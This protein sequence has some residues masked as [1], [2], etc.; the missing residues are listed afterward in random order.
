MRNSSDFQQFLYFTPS[1]PQSPFL[2]FNQQEDYPYFPH[3]RD[4]EMPSENL[5]VY[6]AKLLNLVVRKRTKK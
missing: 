6:N 5:K 1:V 2:I 3:Q 4:Q